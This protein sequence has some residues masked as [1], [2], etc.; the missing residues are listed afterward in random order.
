M[1][2][3]LKYTVFTFLFLFNVAAAQSGSNIK[4][5][6]SELAK[7]Q[8]DIK[9]LETDLSQQ[10]ENEKQSGKLLDNINHQLLLLNKIIQKYRKEERQL[11]RKI[12][13]L[14]TE[15]N[16]LKSEI[17]K[18]QDDYARYV[19]WLYMNAHDS[20]LGFLINSDSFNQAI[21]RYKYLN[22]ITDK[23]EERLVELVANKKA[24]EE[25][26]VA[27]KKENSKKHKLLVEKRKEKN[28]LVKREKE[29]EK[30]IAQLK[31]NQ[32][33]IAK[34]IDEKRKYEVEIKNRI[35]K[36]IEEERQ[37]KIKLH[38]E[39]F[40]GESVSSTIPRFDYSNFENFSDLKGNM[41]WPVS[42]GKVVRD[43]GENKN[44]KLK[45]VTL[46]YGIDIQ[47]KPKEE[48]HAVAQGVV[49]V[50]DWVPGFGSIIIITHK[51]DFRTVYGHIVNIQVNEGD[52]VNA[53][54]L[55]GVVNE[56]LEGNIIHF[57]IWNERNYQ[58]PENWLVKK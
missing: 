17:K 13:G 40:K 8:R 9:K 54:T 51:G 19:R 52:I 22:Y 30:L 12:N 10:K 35:A 16:S 15:I 4:Q 26:T 44:V 47:T 6:N 11:D 20:K 37:R 21:V 25:K 32:S 57:E 50:I 1:V 33:N 23:N 7:I 29:K 39:N 27:L 5:K 38:E 45:T 53:G 14:T 46:N 18:L 48:V 28:R 36:L 56:S 43:F 41:S 3:Y 49:S 24:L 2:R 34:E 42:T 55:L 58:N 31:K